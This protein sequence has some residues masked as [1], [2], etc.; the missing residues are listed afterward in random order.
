MSYL[1]V[2]FIRKKSKHS[3]EIISLISEREATKGT[4]ILHN[5]TWISVWQ[6]AKIV[7]YFPKSSSESK[8][9]QK[10]K[11]KNQSNY[12]IPAICIQKSLLGFQARAE[13]PS[14]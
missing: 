5:S 1:S 6:I 10:Q 4:H 13:F 12:L 3:L 9:V 8:A 7:M 11:Q 2:S 14:S